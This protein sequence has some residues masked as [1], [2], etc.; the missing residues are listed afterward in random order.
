MF[1]NCFIGQF[2][3]GMDIDGDVDGILAQ[4]LSRMGTNDREIIIK[5]F[6]Q[7]IGGNLE[8]C[9]ETCTFFLEMNNWNLQEAVGSYYDYGANGMTGCPPQYTTHLPSMLF[10]KDI[11]IGEGESVPPS[12][13][14]TKTWRVKNT[15]AECWPSGC[16]ISFMEGAQLSDVSRLWVASLKPDEEGDI[17]VEMISPADKGIYQSRWQLNTMAGIPFG[18]SIWCIVTV[19]D[20]GILDITQKLASAPLDDFS[21]TSGTCL[22]SFSPAFI[23]NKNFELRKDKSQEIEHTDDNNMDNI[24]FDPPESPNGSSSLYNAVISRLPQVFWESFN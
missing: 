16:F 20:M 8:Q 23:D 24:A 4:E 21:S 22:N 18:E 3:S 12:T 7:L 1:F 2:F 15:G 5:Q 14:F 9:P 17:S 10:I 13:R 11:T 6:Q 19:D